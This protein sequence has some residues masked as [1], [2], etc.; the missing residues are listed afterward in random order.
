MS[1]AVAGGSKREGEK[2]AL[3]WYSL[4]VEAD[5]ISQR[6]KNQMLVNSK[7]NKAFATF[8]SG[9]LELDEDVQWPEGARLEVRLLAENNA[10][11]DEV[12]PEFLDAMNDPDRFG[13]TEEEWPQTEAERQIWLKWFDSIEPMDMSTD[14]L[15]AM[16]ADRLAMKKIQRDFTRKSWGKVDRIFE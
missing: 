12:R 15:E 5:R 10:R 3:P 8:R 2:R 16:E 6:S 9:K 14:E 4:P 11:E 13:L 1:P 7:V